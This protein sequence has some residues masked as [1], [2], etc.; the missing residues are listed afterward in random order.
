MDED[1]GQ[2]KRLGI[3]K[4]S[5]LDLQPEVE[6]EI[7]LKLQPSLDMMK[8]KDKKDRGTLSIKVLSRL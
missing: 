7:E 4:L 5:L 8:I 2:D 6:K 3:V 1:I